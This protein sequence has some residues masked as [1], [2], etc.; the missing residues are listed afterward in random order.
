M[1]SHR[2]QEKLKSEESGIFQY[3]DDNFYNFLLKTSKGKRNNKIRFRNKI[4]KI[5]TPNDA[6][7]IKTYIDID[8]IK[9]NRMFKKILLNDPSTL[10]YILNNIRNIKMY[11]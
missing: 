1:E 2:N 11:K 6:F 7:L 5:I 10:E 4:V 8:I 9:Y 3:F